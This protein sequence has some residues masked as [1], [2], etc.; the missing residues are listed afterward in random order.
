L[1]H[2]SIILSNDNIDILLDH[3]FNAEAFN[4]GWKILSKILSIKFKQIFLMKQIDEKN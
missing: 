4:K 3:W 2:S 1:N